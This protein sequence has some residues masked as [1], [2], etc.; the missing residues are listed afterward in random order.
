M[1]WLLAG[2]G[3]AAPAHGQGA[4]AELGLVP[5][6]ASLERG[7]GAFR[8]TATTR[9]AFQPSDD[10]ELR[11]AA[12]FWLAEA[13][14]YTG[15]DLAESPREAPSGV[16]DAPGGPGV[17]AFRLDPAVPGGREAY[18]LTI[19]PGGLALSASSAA[20]IFYGVQ[21]LRQLSP[22]AL[23][24]GLGDAPAARGLELPAVR[25]SDA[26]RFTYRGLHLDVGRHMFPVAF[27]KRYV[28]LLARLKLNT[29]HWHLTE[30]QGWRIEILAYPRLTQVGA[31]R[32]E[33]MVEKN[34]DPYVGDGVR[35]GGYYTRDEI[36]EVVAYASARHVTVIPE[37]E[38]PGHSLAALA[39]YPELACTEGPFEV[40]T[41]WGVYDDIYCPSERTFEF[42][43][44]VLT[45]V[46]ALF[47]GPYIH[48]GGDEAPKRRWRESELAQ[49]VIRDHGLTDEDELQSWFIERIE[50]F[51]AAHGRR[52]IGWDEILEGGLPERATVMSW[53]GVGGGIEAARQGHD[54]IMTPGSHLYFDHYQS[55]D[56]AAEPLAIG[57][58]TPLRKVYDFEPVPDVLT[59]AQRAHVLGAQANVWTE[60]IKTPEHVEY[61]AYPRALALAEVVWS[62]AAARD[63]G[64]F[65]RR[66]P[67]ALARLDALGVNY[68]PPD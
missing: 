16:D 55:R 48:I 62:P 31:W 4:A 18:R 37:I 9:V 53:R 51:L 42:L 40:G 67:R 47:P 10:A 64:D 11:A 34:F 59:G 22:P 32:R 45:E 58:F 66:L 23:G 6:P 52:L 68:R 26:P 17:I 60:Y 14:A 3:G 19:D 65:R 41:R 54:V 29:F 2:W 24:A 43:E 39:A 61:M 12:E 7:A 5:R 13:R 49:R 56:R 46:M 8:L 36:R 35:Y 50:R 44:T 20:G 1:A 33:T 30:D 57:G 21:T 63:W 38:M 15:L 27:I 28:D 25:I